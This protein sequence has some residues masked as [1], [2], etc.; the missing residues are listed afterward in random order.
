VYKSKREIY[1]SMLNLIVNEIDNQTTITVWDDLLS[2]ICCVCEDDIMTSKEQLSIKI[3][4]Q[5]SSRGTRTHKKNKR[6]VPM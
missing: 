2:V 6:R 5:K 4:R 3:K 1:S